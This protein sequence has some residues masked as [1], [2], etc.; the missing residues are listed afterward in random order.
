MVLMDLFAGPQ[1]RHRRREQTCGLSGGS[2][3][4][5]GM[6]RESSIE[7]YTFTSVQSLSRVRLSATPWTAARQASRSITNSPSLLRLMSIESVMPSNHLLL[8]PPLLLPP[9]IFPGIRDFPRESVLHI[10]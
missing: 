6:N 7:I 9:L 8:C 5:A 4:D 3:G 10:R 2:R 1:W